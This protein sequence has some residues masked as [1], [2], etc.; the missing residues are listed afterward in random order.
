MFKFG[1]KRHMQQLRCRSHDDAAYET[2]LL[3]YQAL[4]RS[5]IDYAAP[6]WAPVI[7]NTTWRYLQTTQNRY[8]L[9]QDVTCRSFTY[10]TKLLPGISDVCPE[11][12]VAPH[13]V[14]HL[15]N[16]QS[17]PTQLTAQDLWDDTA[18]VADFLNLDN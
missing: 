5:V 16:C 8:W 4:G 10:G 15:V 6:V 14:E 9:S 1:G 11:C 12:G 3:T 13:S 17:N 18:A 7:N 2:L